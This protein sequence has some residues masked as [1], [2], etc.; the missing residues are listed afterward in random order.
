MSE[1]SPETSM[2]VLHYRLC[3]VDMTCAL[4]SPFRN[5][6]PITSDAGGAASKQPSALSGRKLPCPPSHP[7]LR[8]AH[9]WWLAWGYV[10]HLNL[11]QGSPEAH[12][13][14]E[15]PQR[16]LGAPL[17]LHAGACSLPLLPSMGADCRIL[18]GKPVC[19]P[20]NPTRD[21]AWKNE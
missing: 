6:Q 15:L 9:I 19:F 14:S 12:G 17:G 11:A 10:E 7:L 21:R 1:W 16:G 2:C 20:G 8:S 18:P 13:S 3:A 4:Q 5:T